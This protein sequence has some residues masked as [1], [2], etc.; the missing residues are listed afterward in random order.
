MYTTVDCKY[1]CLRD[2]FGKFVLMKLNAELEKLGV[3]IKQ[4]VMISSAGS[5]ICLGCWHRSR[6]SSVKPETQ[7]T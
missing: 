7:F 4:S 5:Y 2:R 1:E 6:A 3:T